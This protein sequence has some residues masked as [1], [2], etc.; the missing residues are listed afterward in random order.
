MKL[1][2][3]MDELVYAKP[4]KM[5]DTADAGEER[6]DSANRVGSVDQI[7]LGIVRGVYEG[8]FVPG[9]KLI[10]GDLT[11]RFSVGRGTIREALRRL[12]AEGLVVAS[13]HRGF[14]IRHFSRDEVRD[15]LEINATII[16]LAA[17]LA[18]QR[19]ER[20]Q[21]VNALRAVVSKMAHSI[22]EGN[23]FDLASLRFDFMRELVKL[24]KNKE[25]SRHLPRFDATII[26]AQFR[27]TFS[28][29][30]AHADVAAF[31]SMVRSI[32]AR[33]AEG[34]AQIGRDYVR[35]WSTSIQ[36]LSDEH[37]AH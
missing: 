23:A 37:F 35:S 15:I 11:R 18:A 36:E 1:S 5:S 27:A 4:S 9:Q 21:D 3:E 28:V 24:T 20:S 19:F 2:E 10:E 34:A 8:R 16:S 22:G 17:S 26:R 31:D 12:E 30:N 14:R 25:L 29:K 13:L 6:V 7:V 32:L 33:D